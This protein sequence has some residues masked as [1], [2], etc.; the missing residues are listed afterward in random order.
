M[1]LKN[2]IYKMDLRNILPKSSL[3][4]PI[5][6]ALLIGIISIF[7]PN[8]YK[9]YF[10]F[11]GLILFFPMIIVDLIKF[12]EEDKLYGTN[13]FWMSVLNLFVMIVIM[14]ALLFATKN[15]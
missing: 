11:C 7:I 6:I 1:S 14:V 9:E 2:I 5:T 12:R 15:I 13:K 4:T 8:G 10:R 3:F